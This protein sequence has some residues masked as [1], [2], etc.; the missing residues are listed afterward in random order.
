MLLGYAVDLDGTGTGTPR[1]P[2]LASRVLIQR[3]FCG[4][5]ESGNGGYSSGL[6]ARELG[7]DGPVEVTLRTP[8]PL[9]TELRTVRTPDGVEVRH[10]D[11]LVGE[12]RAGAVDVPV[13]DPVSWDDAVRAAEAYP[14]HRE[15]PYPTCF[16]CGPARAEG[17][18]LRIFAGPVA[19]REIAASPWV[20][21]AS[22]AGDDGT[23]VRR[24]YVWA[25]LDCPSWFGF[26]DFSTWEGRPLLGRLTADVRTLPRV[27]ERLVASGWTLGR[28]GRKIHVASALHRED[29]EL[30]GLAKAVWL[31][32]LDG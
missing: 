18:G 22:L 5:S 27:G 1:G 4:P 7:L 28:D 30:L 20:P 21:H 9:D 29:G 16:V 23:T 26:A 6:I 19:G 24:E 11:V 17:D 2:G 8:P 32:V 14:G 31:T 15:H 3:R 25:A 13:P 10:G 12:A